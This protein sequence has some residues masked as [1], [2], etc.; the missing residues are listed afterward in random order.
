[1]YHCHLIRLKHHHQIAILPPSTIITID[2]HKNSIICLYPSLSFYT[3][4]PPDPPPPPL[5][6]ITIIKKT[7][8]LTPKPPILHPH[9]EP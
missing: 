5:A 8:V 1:M 7:S 9:P 4:P 6:S 3:T 2:L